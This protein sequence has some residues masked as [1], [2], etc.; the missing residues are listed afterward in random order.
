[1]KVEGNYKYSGTLSLTSALDGVGGQ[2]HAPVALPPGKTQYLL[3]RRMGGPQG[4]AGSVRKISLQP[5]FNPRPV[6]PIAS[7]YTY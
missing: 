1:M 3:Y 4:R 6:R 7:C 2:R 5:G